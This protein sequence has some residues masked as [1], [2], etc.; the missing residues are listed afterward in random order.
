[1]QPPP[2]WLIYYSTCS[3]L[4]FFITTSFYNNMHFVWCAPVFNPKSLD[5]NDLR[6]KIPPSSSPYYIYWQYK[7]AVVSN[8]LHSKL[9]ED[10]KDGIMKGATIRFGKQEI[11]QSEFTRITEMVEQATIQEFEPKIYVIPA[12]KVAS[13]LILVSVEKSA[14]PLS[15]EYKI[16]DLTIGEFD[17]IEVAK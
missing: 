7:E 3:T 2:D 15:T 17:I 13:K 4:A 14:N 6:S 9:I 12:D 8:D 1:M 5:T 11:T 10:N 16:E